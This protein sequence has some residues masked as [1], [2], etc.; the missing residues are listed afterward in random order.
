MALVDSSLTYSLTLPT[1][2]DQ[3]PIPGNF[4][5]ARDLNAMPTVALDPKCTGKLTVRLPNLFIDMMADD[6]AANT[7][8]TTVKPEADGW[9]KE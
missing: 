5:A 3:H 6:Y 8:Y 9:I 2:A 7:F 4:S 1:D